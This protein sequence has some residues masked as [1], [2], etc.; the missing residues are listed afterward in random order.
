MQYSAMIS[1]GS[2]TTNEQDMIE[3]IC[4][5]KIRGQGCYNDLNFDSSYHFD[6]FILHVPFFFLLFA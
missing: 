6:H 2:P 1:L 3:L 4:I 5:G